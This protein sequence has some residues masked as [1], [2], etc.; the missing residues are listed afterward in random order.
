MTPEQQRKAA[1]L[2]RR[3]MVFAPFRIIDR[4]AARRSLGNE[5]E[6]FLATIAETEAAQ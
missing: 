6:E 1:E 5:I 2:L 3:S 4:P